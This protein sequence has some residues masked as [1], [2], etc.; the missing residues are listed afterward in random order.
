MI[1]EPASMPHQKQYVQL[2]RVE[3]DTNYSQFRRPDEYYVCHHR[4]GMVDVLFVKTCK[5]SSGVWLGYPPS[6]VTLRVA[7]KHTQAHPEIRHYRFGNPRPR[8]LSRVI[9]QMLVIS[10][11]ITNSENI[12]SIWFL[13]HF[14]VGRLVSIFFVL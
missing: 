2:L 4:T 14:M 10:S 12:L 9:H 13:D 6:W 11:R 3:V 5:P 1:H 7:E 8:C